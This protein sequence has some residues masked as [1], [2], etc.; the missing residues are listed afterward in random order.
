MTSFCSHV[1]KTIP[2]NSP[3][4]LKAQRLRN[5]GRTSCGAEQEKNLAVLGVLGQSLLD[6]M[7]KGHYS[8]T[9]I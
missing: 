1:W 6:G 7:H 4:Y 3:G 5:W 8:V 9:I 2:W